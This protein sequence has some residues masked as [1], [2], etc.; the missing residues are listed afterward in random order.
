MQGSLH[1]H[2]IK[3]KYLYIVKIEDYIQLYSYAVMQF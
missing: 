2:N 3:W 1:G